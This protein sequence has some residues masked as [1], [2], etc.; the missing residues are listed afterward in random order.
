MFKTVSLFILATISINHVQAAEQ[1]KSAAEKS[2]QI[3]QTRCVQI[4]RA[5]KQ[6]SRAA[7]L[8]ASSMIPDIADIIYLY[9]SPT[10][11]EILTNLDPAHMILDHTPPLTVALSLHGRFYV[12]SSTYCP[13][14]FC[15]SQAQ[16]EPDYE[17]QPW[18]PYNPASLQ[19]PSSIRWSHGINEGQYTCTVTIH[20]SLTAKFFPEINKRIGKTYILQGHSQPI[21]I[22]SIMPSDKIITGSED[23]TVKIWEESTCR[24]IQTINT[25][26]GPIKSIEMANDDIIITTQH[27]DKTF[28]SPQPGALHA[29][30][31]N[32]SLDQLIKLRELIQH[33]ENQ[34]PHIALQFPAVDMQLSQN[35][36]DFLATLPTNIQATLLKNYPRILL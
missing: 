33:L 31:H 20:A 13:T 8:A 6:P 3:D 34:P 28:Y 23:G 2:T 11:E 27:G 36:K 19:H 17:N 24:C 1:K 29:I 5:L 10:Q 9:W 14:Y 21:T 25:H 22:A 30:M 26:H 15:K 18:Q 16:H 12:D 35:D 4:K 7:L 32:L